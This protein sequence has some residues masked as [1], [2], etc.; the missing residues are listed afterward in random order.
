MK[1]YSVMLKREQNDRVIG[2]AYYLDI[3]RAIKKYND[4]VKY[5]VEGFPIVLGYYEENVESTEELR[6]LKERQLVNYHEIY[7]GKVFKNKL[8]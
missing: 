2:E 1:I 3:K 7:D 4:S 8:S 6:E 5:F